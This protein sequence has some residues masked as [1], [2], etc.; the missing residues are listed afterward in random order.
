[1]PYPVP[2]EWS[3]KGIREFLQ[4]RKAED[5]HFE[6]KAFLH[7]DTKLKYDA[8]KH[9]FPDLASKP[10]H[11][12]KPANSFL[13]YRVIESI[14]AFA[15]SDGG[16]L[17]LGIGEPINNVAPADFSIPIIGASGKNRFDVT[18]V[19]RDGIGFSNEYFE[20]D[21]YKR[22]L[23]DILFPKAKKGIQKYF[24]IEINPGGKINKKERHIKFSSAY[25]ED[26]IEDIKL[27]PF[28]TTAGKEKII[29]AILVKRSKEPITVTEIRDGYEIPKLPIR[30]AFNN[31]GPY[32]G[33]DL[34]NFI[35][36]RDTAESDVYRHTKN[37]IDYVPI[38]FRD[39]LKSYVIPSQDGT[40]LTETI[41]SF[42]NKKENV[43]IMGESGMGKSLLMSHCYLKFS[44]EYSSIFHSIDRT[45]GP[46]VYESAPVLCR[47]REQIESLEGMPTVNP[48]QKTGSKVPWVWERDYLTEVLEAWSNFEPRERLILFLDGLDENY[49]ETR[50]TEFILNILQPLIRRTNL[51]ATWVL[52]SQRRKG[53][54]WIDKFFQVVE[55][56]GLGR[57]EA[58]KLA[59]KLL[60]A[61][62]QNYLNE[63]L[64]KS[65]MDSDLYDPETVVVVARAC[66]ESHVVPFP[67]PPVI[68]KFIENL[69]LSYRN[70]YLWMFEHYTDPAKVENLPNLKIS[71]DT[72]ANAGSDVPYQKFLYDILTILVLLRRPI[73]LDIL[74]WALELENKNQQHDYRGRV[75]QSFRKYHAHIIE[76][77]CFLQRAVDDLRRFVKVLDEKDGALSFCK[78]AMRESFLLFV[79]KNIRISAEKR[80]ATLA[81]EEIDLLAKEDLGERPPYLLTEIFYLLSLNPQTSEDGL[82]KLFL[83]DRFPE[84]LQMSVK[85]SSIPSI[86]R[87]LR[88]AEAFNM[89]EEVRTKIKDITELIRDWS[90]Q[91]NDYPFIFASFLRN[92]S[93]TKHYWPTFNNEIPLLVPLGGY[94]RKINEHIDNITCFAVL[95]DGRIATGSNDCDIRIWDPQTCTC[96]ILGGSTSSVECFA[97][98]PDGRLA[99]GDEH[100]YITI[101][102]TETHERLV[103]KH[104]GKA[105][106]PNL[107][108]EYVNCLATLPD[109]SLISGG[110][111]GNIVIW[112]TDSGAPLETIAL[113]EGL[114][115]IDVLADGRMT[116]AFGYLVDSENTII[117]IWDDRTEEPIG[118][119]ET[120]RFLSVLNDGRIALR[121]DFEGSF[122]IIDRNTEEA[123][124]YEGHTEPVTCLI[125]L[126]NGTIATGSEDKTIRIWDLETGIS[127]LFEGHIQPVRCLSF[128]YDGRLASGDDEGSIR[129]WNI[130]NGESLVLEGH[131]R[132]IVLLA[133]LPNGHLA[134]GSQDT[135]RTWN[136]QTGESKILMGGD[137]GFEKKIVVLSDGYVASLTPGDTSVVISNSITGENKI[138]EH[139][140]EKIYDLE[141]LPDKN[142]LFS[143]CNTVTVW[144]THT[145]KSQILIKSEESTT[146]Q[147]ILP[148]QHLANVEIVDNNKIRI[149]D[150][151]TGSIKNLSEQGYRMDSIT[152]L[153]KGFIA[154][155]S[156]WN[157]ARIWNIDTGHSEVLDDYVSCILP[158]PENYLAAGSSD[159][160]V[161]IWD[162]T[163]ETIKLD[164]LGILEAPAD[165]LYYYEGILVV[166]MSHRMELF[167]LNLPRLSPSSG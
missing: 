45:Q 145:W 12:A 107:P 95:N 161:I 20:D 86:L 127:E 143:S 98:L 62:F 53:M 31:N 77:G 150:T 71:A 34:L 63:L 113:C 155:I 37:P 123:V 121:C 93:N 1:M 144:N 70:K 9:N 68:L 47:L 134:S 117:G 138:L 56:K 96:K 29:T 122:K 8:E 97:V 41:A 110:P 38:H 76:D 158:L 24:K 13:A 5:K 151:V 22:E 36:T 28:Y 99:S 147:V 16:L 17:L 105:V 10:F 60:P 106:D 81:L 66:A 23:K 58:E 166:P 94:K 132:R 67:S 84:W 128:L 116:F 33:D 4:S 49:P 162:F 100:G 69:T 149:T 129:L 19:E 101:W 50:E 7:F 52:S 146:V 140:G 148:N 163:G 73:P 88:T 167:N 126:P 136:I 79:D 61:S 80:L 11:S 55:L 157:D 65:H 141:F 14:I 92:G 118:L 91:L 18:G 59:L 48:P 42:L 142:L 39:E 137:S 153:P 164:K 64:K 83:L 152:I 21:K 139:N 160:T 32:T 130:Q 115:S 78:E 108:H 89:D 102:N 90:S 104:E 15:N 27:I 156:I 154:S 30:L 159:R 119:K 114:S 82:N 131:K 25:R 51:N 57:S 109:G 3:E 54:A 44:D 74:S 40:D 103:L 26:I 133:V 165:K 111:R 120:G 43:F 85:N 2:K 125:E 6:C 135:I 46:A 72:W 35:R 87:E 112:D 124:I 75:R